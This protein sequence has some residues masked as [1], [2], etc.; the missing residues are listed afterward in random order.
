MDSRLGTRGVEE[1]KVTTLTGSPC[2]LTIP[3]NTGINLISNLVMYYGNV[4]TLCLE[5]TC[6]FYALII[7][8]SPLLT[9]LHLIFQ[10]HPWFKGVQ[11]DMLYELEAAYK[12]T[13]TGDLDT[14][15]FEK[16][17]E[18]SIYYIKVYAL[19]M[20]QIYS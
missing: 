4:S 18:V 9:N 10:A 12:P 7:C 3:S 6:Y 17:P 16:F 5:S 13:V 8:I 19:R 20:S 2:F 14:Q 1:I 11:W 15:N